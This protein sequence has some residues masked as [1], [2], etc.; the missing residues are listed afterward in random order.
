MWSVF[1][2]WQ[3]QTSTTH[4]VNWNS[5]VWK[6][7]FLYLFYIQWHSDMFA[8]TL[9]PTTVTIIKCEK[10]HKRQSCWWIT[11]PRSSINWT[12][13]HQ[14]FWFLLLCKYLCVWKVWS[15]QGQVSCVPCTL[16][17]LSDYCP[18]VMSDAGRTP[19]GTKTYWSYKTL[20]YPTFSHPSFS[21]FSHFLDVILSPGFFKRIM[22]VIVV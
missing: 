18:F 20:S 5:S 10:L 3:K 19:D 12:H 14:C 6:K 8:N 1:L 7:Y 21:F 9:Q 11:C 17:T 13:C 22:E 15:Y 16:T 4:S 2:L